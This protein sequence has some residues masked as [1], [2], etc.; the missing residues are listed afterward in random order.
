[1]GTEDEILGTEDEIQAEVGERPGRG[2][3]SRGGEKEYFFTGLSPW[4]VHPYTGDREEA[5]TQEKGKKR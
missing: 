1:M 2:K 4:G 5:G 3:G